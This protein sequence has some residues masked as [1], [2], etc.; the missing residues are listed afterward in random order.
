MYVEFCCKIKHIAT[1]NKNKIVSA[2]QFCCLRVPF[3]IIGIMNLEIFN[4]E[5]VEFLNYELCKFECCCLVFVSNC[6]LFNL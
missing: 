2:F 5:I 4:F 6:F 1:H 3:C